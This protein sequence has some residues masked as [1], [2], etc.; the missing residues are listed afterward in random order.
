MAMDVATLSPHFIESTLRLA[1]AEHF[2]EFFHLNSPK[3]EGFRKSRS[4]LMSGKGYDMSIFLAHVEYIR[5]LETLVKSLLDRIG[6]TQEQF[7]SALVASG[8][9]DAVVKECK[10][11]LSRYQD[12]DSFSEMMEDQFNKRYQLNTNPLNSVSTVPQKC[13]VRVLWDLENVKVPKHLGGIRTVSALNNFLRSVGLGGVG[14][15]TR[16]TAFFAQGRVA[17]AVVQA[18]DKAAV[19]LVW[20]STKREDA[21]RKLGTR[22][23]QEMSVL[24]PQSTTIVVISSDQDFRTHIQQLNNGGF[25]SVVIHDAPDKSNWSETLVL[26]AHTSYRWADVL[27]GTGTEDYGGKVDAVVEGDE[28]SEDNDESVPRAPLVVATTATATATATATTT[29]ATSAGN[30]VQAHVLGEG[31]RW[32]LSAFPREVICGCSHTGTVHSWRGA[33]GFV[34]ISLPAHG[35]VRNGNGINSDTDTVRVYVHTSVLPERELADGTSAKMLPSKG[36][37][38]KVLVESGDRGLF[39]QSFFICDDLSSLR[40]S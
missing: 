16:I 1:Y 15:D 22:I 30:E 24:P 17:K 35:K 29:G 37:K 19:E 9:S 11:H 26:H 40:P 14:T 31:G 32:I 12:F 3:F 13:V 28:E 21:D 39:A 2:E 18:L 27:A 23:M 20:V 6:V 36:Q 25:K 5:S 4:N 38:V 8:E 10:F 7:V 34:V 33:F